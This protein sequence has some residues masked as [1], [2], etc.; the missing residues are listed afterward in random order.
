MNKKIFENKEYVI[1]SY[2]DVRRHKGCR[3]YRVHFFSDEKTTN[4]MKKKSFITKDYQTV[5]K[6]LGK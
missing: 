1:Y 4:V 3:T 6:Y 5:K 2:G